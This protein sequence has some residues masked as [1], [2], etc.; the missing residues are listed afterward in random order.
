MRVDETRLLMLGGSANPRGK[1]EY[2]IASDTWTPLQDLPFSFQNGACLTTD[3]PGN[4]WLWYNKASQAVSYVHRWLLWIWKGSWNSHSLLLPPRHCIK[5]RECRSLPA[6]LPGMEA[7][8]IWITHIHFYIA[9]PT[10]LS[11]W[12]KMICGVCKFQNLTHKT[13]FSH[14][15]ER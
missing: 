12:W 8:E 3:M 2:N 4:L 5:C 14:Y 13:S 7:M 9:R 11:K 6:L 1:V 15:V 10:L